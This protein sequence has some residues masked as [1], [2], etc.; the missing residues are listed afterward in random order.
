M[1]VAIDGFGLVIGFT[2]HYNTTRDYT[3]Q[4]IVVCRSLYRSSGNGFQ[5]ER[6]ASSGFPNW[7]DAS[8]AATLG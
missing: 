7:P 4:I 8:T 1:T 6:S 3:L 5:G 2:G